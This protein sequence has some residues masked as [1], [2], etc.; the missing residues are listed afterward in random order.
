MD[1][2]QC[3]RPQTCRYITYM[4]DT[5]HKHV[6]MVRL[7]LYTP[8]KNNLD[9]NITHEAHIYKIYIVKISGWG[10]GSKSLDFTIK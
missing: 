1:L 7:Y 9:I 2:R 3:Y 6:G 5:D 10:N 4:V 8:L